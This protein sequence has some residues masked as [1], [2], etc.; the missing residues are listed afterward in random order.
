[1]PALRFLPTDEATSAEA[2]RILTEVRF[3]HHAVPARWLGHPSIPWLQG[4]L[5]VAGA[6][7][8]WRTRLRWVFSTLL[9]LGLVLLAI[10]LFTGSQELALLF[11][12][13]VSTVLMPVAFSLVAGSLSRRLWARQTSRFAGAFVAL[14]AM[15]AAGYGYA[16][17][18]GELQKYHRD[19]LVGL[20]SAA[21]AM[22]APQT[23]FAVPTSMERFRLETGARTF[24]DFK[25]HPYKDTEVVEWH[26]RVALANELDGNDPLRVC[27]VATRL[28]VQYGVT[29]FVRPSRRPL[30]CAGLVTAF[31]DENFLIERWDQDSAGAE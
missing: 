21:S 24:I 27:D 29:H 20:L 13:R 28:H 16:H 1:L 9:A 5:L 15:L 31:R 30:S 10:Q 4:P 6:I 22:A 11:P 12:W 23:L 2:A 3:P 8:A 17:T 25:A 19:R 18:R 26:A 14:G 7:A